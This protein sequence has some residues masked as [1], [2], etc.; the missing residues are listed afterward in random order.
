M[1]AMFEALA[2]GM[3]V[4]AGVRVG[5]P[6][7]DGVDDAAPKANDG[8]VPKADEDG[9]APKAVTRGLLPPAA[10]APAKRGAR[11]EPKRGTGVA[12]ALVV[13]VAPGKPKADGRCLFHDALEVVVV[14]AVAVEV[15]NDGT[16]NG[17]VTEVEVVVV[18]ANL[19]GGGEG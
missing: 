16:E 18:A 5:T 3:V 12:D 4:V 19:A 13:G 6:K 15:G 2:V 14:V 9:V 8:D 17:L 11:G 7:R 10:A 1:E